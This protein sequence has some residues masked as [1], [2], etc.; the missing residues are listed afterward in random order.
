MEML[1]SPSRILSTVAKEKDSHLLTLI[2]LFII[3][4]RHFEESLCR[5][6]PFNVRS[7]NRLSNDKKA[8]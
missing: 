3:L 8:Q 6:F 1:V 4:C 5:S 7:D 2:Y